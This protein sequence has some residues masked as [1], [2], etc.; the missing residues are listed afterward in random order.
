MHKIPQLPYRKYI[1]RKFNFCSAFDGFGI[2]QR[3]FMIL[4]NT[5]PCV[6][7]HEFCASGRDLD[8]ACKIYSSN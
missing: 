1:V 7:G 5:L 8:D 2:S 6:T 4:R 3:E